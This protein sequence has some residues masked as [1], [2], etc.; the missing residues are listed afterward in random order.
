MDKDVLDKAEA[1][2]VLLENRVYIDH[3]NMPDK[4]SEAYYDAMNDLKEAV[5]LQRGDQ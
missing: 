5:G 2:I 4:I 1:L 3:W